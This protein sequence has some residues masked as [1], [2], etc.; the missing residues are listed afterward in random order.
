MTSFLERESKMRK[1]E[2]LKRLSNALSDMPRSERNDI[3]DYYDELIE[4]RLDRS[5]ISESEVIRELGSIEDIARRVRSKDS[6]HTRIHYDEYEPSKRSSNK[7]TSGLG[8]LVLI[9][10]IPLW[11][12]L[13]AVLFSLIITVI[14]GTIGVFVGGCA[15]IIFGC[16]SLGETLTMGL[17]EIG[18]GIFI[19]GAIVL[20]SPIIIKLIVWLVKLLVKFINWLCH[21]RSG[22]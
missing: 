21:G 11:I 13:F 19:I 2:F 5:R 14:A 18:L 9:L 15:S 20:L 8:I 12:V 10:L 17:F 16:M 4:D 3:I 6:G 1:K 7:R 22:R